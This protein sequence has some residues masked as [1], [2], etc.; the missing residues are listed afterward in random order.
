MARKR[1]IGQRAH[2]AQV[3]RCPRR[4]RPGRCEPPPVA[5]AKPQ[6]AAVATVRPRF[7]SNR[8][9]MLGERKANETACPGMPVAAA[10]AP[11]TR[12][13]ALPAIRQTLVQVGCQP[14]EEARGCP[15]TG[16]PSGTGGLPGTR[17]HRRRLARPAQHLEVT[18]QLCRAVGALLT[19]SF[20]P[21]L[22][23]TIEVGPESS[24]RL[25]ISSLLRCCARPSVPM[26]QPAVEVE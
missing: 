13:L 8:P 5:A 26:A 23:E 14:P 9:T 22:L 11:S 16:T 15:G 18:G 20:V 12:P 1:E 17:R 7:R 6:R 10:P 24:H 4:L 19:D 2:L 25:A 21:G 3:G